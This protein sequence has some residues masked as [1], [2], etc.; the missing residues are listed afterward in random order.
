MAAV[1][2][3]SFQNAYAITFNSGSYVF[4]NAPDSFHYYAEEEKDVVVLTECKSHDSEI[5]IPNEVT[6]EGITYRVV[7]VC[8]DA[9]WPYKGLTSIEF[10]ENMRYVGSG[11]F[12]DNKIKTLTFRSNLERIA[13][14]AFYNCPVENVYIFRDVP[15]RTYGHA[16][17][18]YSITGISIDLKNVFTTYSLFARFGKDSPDMSNYQDCRTIHAT[19]YVP[20]NAVEAYRNS[21]H[22][23]FPGW[24]GV[25]G[26]F[27]NILPIESGTPEI[28]DSMTADSDAPGDVYDITGNLV[29]RHA[30]SD[31][32]S[33]LPAGIY[34]YKG[35]KI[36]R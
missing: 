1:L 26:Y 3:L 2:C 29:L 8:D 13:P 9:K 23:R 32:L 19:L 25:W 18:E 6:H 4:T 10:P 33:Q 35:R 12:R 17:F 27:E 34:I 14:G 24:G 16:R 15:P 11:V 31:A 5:K 20:E 28:T 7:E 30:S 36:I 22:D 21:L